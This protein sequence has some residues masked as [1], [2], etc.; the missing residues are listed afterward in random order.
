ME[1]REIPYIAPGLL[2]EERYLTDRVYPDRN[3]DYYWSDVWDP[4]FF[5]DLARAG[6]IPVAMDH[7]QLGPI[8]LPEMQTAYA[9]LDW[10]DLHVPGHVRK[11]LGRGSLEGRG[12]ALFESNDPNRV[13][14]A[15]RKQFGEE[16]W[17]TARYGKLLGEL[18]A[19]PFPKGYF[20]LRAT[21]LY[22]G[23]LLVAGELGYEIG[24]TYTSLT[25]FSSRL[26][27]HRNRGTLQLVLLA[28]S[29]QQEGFAFWN[30]GHPYMEYK[31][32][33]GARIL[34][35]EDFLARWLPH[36]P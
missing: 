27:E 11:I 15:V 26:R 3:T 33:L 24:G 25:G 29:L 18:A 9:V 30:L 2:G 31:R 10:E 23:D 28:R 36:I 4:L 19:Y 1:K 16:N 22:E 17:L 21:E 6:F 5:A 34:E 13:I 32:A 7:G 12:F 14:A 20:R 8:L 35:R